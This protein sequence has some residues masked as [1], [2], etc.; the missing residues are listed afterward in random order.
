MDE[1]LAEGGGRATGV[2]S[3]VGAGDG[4]AVKSYRLCPLAPAAASRCGLEVVTALSWLSLIGCAFPGDEVIFTR[5]ARMGF[6]GNPTVSGM[7]STA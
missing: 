7:R 5:S 4:E 6:D 1:P 2:G 3:F